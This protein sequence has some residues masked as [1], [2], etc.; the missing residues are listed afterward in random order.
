MPDN[1]RN[2][3]Q[4]L[5]VTKVVWLRANWQWWNTWVDDGLLGSNRLGVRFD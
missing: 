1:C 3:Y 4:M 2:S 5:I